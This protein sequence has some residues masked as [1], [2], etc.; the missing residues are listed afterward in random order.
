M[1]TV[2]FVKITNDDFAEAINKALDLIKYDFKCNTKSVVIKPNMCYYWDSSTGQTTDPK[3]V[4]TLIE[5]IRDRISANAKISIVESDASAMKCKYSF[6]LLG[7]EKVAEEYD[8]SLVNLSEEKTENV[9]VSVDNYDFD[10]SI[11]QIIRDADLR[12]NVP[13]L[14]YMEK[15]RI[16]CAMKNIFGCNP[17]PLKYKLHPKLNENIVALNKAM[18]FHLHILDGN[19]LCG[20]F[21]RRLNL[22]MASQDPVAFDAAA[23]KIAGENPK[24]IKFIKL[25]QKE[26]LGSIR[27]NVNGL[28]PALF[29]KEYPRKEASN[30]L[31]ASVYT[32]A[33]KV[34]L[35]KNE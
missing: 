29:E 30:K 20:V 33:I 27:Y 32:S 15:V 12:I 25:A 8:V 19:V 16:S 18:K 31:I 4:A 3:F 17:T 13:K 22:V 11:P 9:R 35:F 10:I 1:S 34:G 6:P 23:A 24:R 26:G 14:K 5:I 7:Y 21:P 2:S 28:S